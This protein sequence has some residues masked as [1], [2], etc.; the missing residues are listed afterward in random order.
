MLML[1]L[2]IYTVYIYILYDIYIYLDVEPNPTQP[3]PAQPRQDWIGLDWLLLTFSRYLQ[4]TFTGG[5]IDG[6]L[7]SI[8]YV[9][10][11]RH[12]YIYMYIYTF[13]SFMQILFMRVVYRVQC[14]YNVSFIRPDHV[15]P[16]IN[17]DWHLFNST[18]TSTVCPLSVL[19]FVC[20]FSSHICIYT[21]PLIFL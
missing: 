7:V 13:S 2:R 19:R 18:S 17:E 21:P 3:N 4:S 15:S 12:I 8:Y 1:S 16:F 5:E 6:Y 14:I 10:E 9:V 11:S 20:Y